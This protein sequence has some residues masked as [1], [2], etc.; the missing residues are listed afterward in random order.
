MKNRIRD[1]TVEE[2]RA[3]DRLRARATLG[4]RLTGDEYAIVT[5]EEMWEESVKLC[6][7]I[8]ADQRTTTLIGTIGAIIA[9]ERI[10]AYEKR[11]M[12]ED[13][14]AALEAAL[15]AKTEG[16]CTGERIIGGKLRV[17]GGKGK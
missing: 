10:V 8:N 13:R 7:R 11:V 12:L 5:K 17:V 15:V 14:V 9:A 16:R 1:R 3:V 6:D 2:Q 4:E